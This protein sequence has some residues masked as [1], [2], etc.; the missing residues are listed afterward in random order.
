MASK[1]L[2]DEL[3]PQSHATD[4]TLATGKKIAG[5]NTQFKITG[6]ANLNHLQTDGAGNVTWVAPPVVVD[7]LST[8]SQWR[9]T[10]DFTG[11]ANPITS[12]W[13]QA[14]S[15]LGFG[16]LGSSMTE[17]S[18]LFSYPS[19]G[20]WLVNFAGLQQGSAHSHVVINIY[21]TVDNS[22]WYNASEGRTGTYYGYAHTHCA[23]IQKVASISLDR[24]QFRVNYTTTTVTT[25]GHS[26]Y[27]ETSVSFIKIGVL[28]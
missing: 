25:H 28:T 15:P 27:N 7:G 2:V 23:Y 8:A 10:A 26:D 13:E 16:V 17:A 18:G 21:T 5:A 19:T 9:L 22:N 12:N 24:V 1:L 11:A 14:D 4:V 20:Y 6:G 3:A